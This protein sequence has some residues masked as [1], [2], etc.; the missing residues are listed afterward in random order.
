MEKLNALQFLNRIDILGNML[1]LGSAVMFFLAL[2]F[3]N[4][5]TSWGSPRIVGLLVGAAVGIIIF[6][7]W[8]FFR[9]D[10]ALIP[11]RIALQRSV[12]FGCLTAIFL[13]GSLLMHNYYLPIWFQAI[14]GRDAIQSGVDM[15]AYVIP[16]AL[17]SL[18]SGI[19]VS[20]IGYFTPASIF[21]SAIATVGAGLVCTLSIDTS[22]GKWIGYLI[23]TGFG[24]GISI[25]Q[26]FNAAH[27]V[28]SLHDIPIGSAAVTFSQSL[29]GSVFTSV[30]D[31]LLINGLAQAKIPGLDVHTVIYGGATGL[32]KTLQPDQLNQLLNTYND[33][34]RR[35]FICV[36]VLYGVAFLTSCGMEF[37][38]VKKSP[39]HEGD[40]EA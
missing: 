34:L 9:K 13:Y 28:L 33:S 32:I 8:Q 4:S 3:A 30:G 20:K 2:Q 17:A 37:R 39:K 15:L 5:D 10:Q 1:L 36:T 31:T 35:V 23:L 27:T 25:Q 12:A 40:K 22:T 18:I 29:G 6:T 21:G 26:G 24:L 14:K 19:L 11:P 38:S 7:G 16:T